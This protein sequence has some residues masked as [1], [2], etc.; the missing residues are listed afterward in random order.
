[1]TAQTA[2]QPAVSFAPL[3]EKKFGGAIRPEPGPKSDIP[4]VGCDAATLKDLALFLRDDPNAKFDLLLD[5]VSIDRSRLPVA[6]RPR[7]GHR[8]GLSY[9]LYSTRHNQHLRVRVGV[10]EA[11]PKVPTL[12]DTWPA[13]N[14]FEREAWDLMGVTFEGHPNLRRLLTHNGFV[15]HPLR[16]DYEASQRWLCTEEDLLKTELAARTEVEEDIFETMTLNFG[17]SHPATHGTLRCVFRVD[18]EKI[19]AAES[20]CG[21]LHRN[22]EKM[23]EEHTFT[24]VIP[25]TDR[26]NYCSPMIN[27]NGYARTIEQML[28]IEVPP[29]AR[30]VRSI[31]AEFSRIMDHM[32]CV[33][34]NLVD[35]G[36]L[37]NFWY[38][39]QARE[40]IYSLLEA[41]CGARLTSSY[42]RIGGLSNDVPANFADWCRTLCREIEDE[43]K[44]I[45]GLITKNR[46]AHKRMRGTGY[47]SKADAIAYGFTG[48]CL[49]ASGVGYDVRKDAPYDFYDEV[50]FDVPVAD[51][52]DNF[53]RYLVRME[54][55][56]Q[57]IRIIEQLVKKLPGGPIVSD[58]YRVV[59]PPKE[60]VYNEMEGLIYHFK[61]VFEGIK[62]PPGEIYS[63]TEGGNGELGYSLVSDGSGRP[64]RLKV[65]PPCFP[66]FAAFEKM[67]IGGMV[68]D[69]VATLGTLNI[70]AGELDR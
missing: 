37:T 39:Y 47:I 48:P 26:L 52:G 60:M 70:I 53:A 36:A 27:G 22:F 12:V 66:L 56:R 46:I 16:K 15:G 13:A 58:D 45:D 57:S 1:M 61:V 65:R 35:L 2:A 23:A 24:Q 54:E 64:Y 50:D 9:L 10:P 63:F 14:W 59:L 55:M 4:T 11:D 34:T 43:L 31:L 7:D 40:Q 20:E 51:G 30:A 62:V 18:G 44:E 68:S 32:V 49:R 42:A 38:A 41:C 29:R 28:G 21:Y 33:G 5:V 6:M 3:L 8:F 19:V 69:A 67:V 25:Y 17:P